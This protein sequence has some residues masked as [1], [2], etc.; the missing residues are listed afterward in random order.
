MAEA[1][2][3]DPW[4]YGLASVLLVVASAFFVGSEYAVV[5]MR[6]SRLE[7]LS[8]KGSKKAKRLLGTMENLSPLIAGTQIGITIVGIA[9]GAFT[10]PFIT[11]LL[12]R[13]FTRLPPWASQSI[14]LFLV[15]FFLVVLG[16]LVPKYMSLKHPER[17]MLVSITPLMA[18]V[19]VFAPVIWMAQ[20][21]SQFVLKPFG[22]DIAETGKESLPKEELLMLI[23]TGG[24]DGVL[25]K[26]HADL[27]TRALRLDVLD[28]ADIMVH[29]LDVRW[30]DVTSNSAQVLQRLNRIR[31]TRIPVCRGDIDDIVGIAYLHDIVR[32]LNNKDFNLERIVRP[33]VAI[34]EN[35]SIEKIIQTM[36]ENKTQILI[37]MDEYGGTSGLIT[38]E[39]VVE[40]VFG[41]LEDSLESERPNIEIYPGGRVSARSDVR[42]DELVARLSLPLESDDNTDTLATIFVEALGRVPK[43]GDTVETPLGVMRIE[44]M[45]RR[46]ITRV[47][48]Q[49]DATILNPTEDDN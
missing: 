6:R 26:T 32:H 45:A 24:T 2:T 30:L 49:L 47:G 35:L 19:R 44:N 5:S 22:I 13:A 3:G 37:V 41:E 38:L 4:V 8:K 48:I 15:L 9:M 12:S 33:M 29:R 21:T 16:E 31:H 23:Q 17:F 27:V 28:A 34:P 11:D 14:S 25:E 10:E 18:F 43:S 46:R 1:P 20:K 40:E 36:R 39:D 7:S 42:F